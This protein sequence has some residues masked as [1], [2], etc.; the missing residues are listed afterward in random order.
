MGIKIGAL[1][2]VATPAMSDVFAIVQ[3]GVTYKESITQL[4]SLLANAGINTNVTSMTGLTGTIEAPTGIL[5]SNGSLVVAF[6]NSANAVNYFTLLNSDTGVNITLGAEGTDANI[7]VTHASKGTG[8]L[9]FDTLATTNQ[10][11]FVTGTAY[12]H[13]TILNFPNTANTRTVTFPDMTGTIFLSSKANGTE[14]ANAVTASGT[15][16]VITTSAL[17]TAGGA[18][19]AITWTNTFMTTSSIIQLTVMGGTNTTQNIVLVA[20]AGAGTSTLTIYN[21]TAATALNGTIFIGYTV[22][23]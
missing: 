20:T 22:I 9:S 6:T 12:Q 21:L 4:T 8:V 10:V 5:D 13:A 7:G 2:S 1:T 18:S 11:Q 16:G 23:P 14:A 19:Y 3:A 15:S 17:T